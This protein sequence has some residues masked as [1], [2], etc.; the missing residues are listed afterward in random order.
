MTITEL[1]HL[2]KGKRNKHVPSVIPTGKDKL[3]ETDVLQ[4]LKDV[5]PDAVFFTTI[6]RLDPEETETATETGESNEFVQPLREL[7]SEKGGQEVN[8]DELNFIWSNYKCSQ[9]QAHNLETETKGQSVCPLWYEQR[10][11]RITASKAHDI[12]VRKQ[13]TNPNNLI[14][15]VTGSKCYNLSNMKPVKWG[16]NNEEKAKLAYICKMK[17]TH[18]SLQVNQSGLLIDYKKPFLAASPDGYVKCNCCEDR[19][20]EIKC[21]Y[22]Y[23]EKK[24]SE[25]NDKTFFITEDGSLKRTH[26]YFTQVQ[27]QMYVF[28]LKSCD[29]VVYTNKEC[30][31]I[32]IPYDKEFCDQLVKVCEKFFFTFIL[33]E[34]VTRKLE[35]SVN[36]CNSTSEPIDTGKTDIWC[37]CRE[38]E[39]GRMIECSNEDCPTQWYHYECVNIR[40]CPR[41]KWICPECSEI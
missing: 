24:I 25:I 18:K 40:R 35:N 20:L 28:G 17:T 19:L 32:A 22:K 27:L 11:G 29:F 30:H 8:N 31:V 4:S 1:Q 15:L 26:R 7:Y 36:S 34:L 6:P 14:K 13:T 21:P 37:L 33:P 16:Q 10:K 3:P 23:K 39:Y 38:P 12:L 2:I 41:G 9:Q 5:C